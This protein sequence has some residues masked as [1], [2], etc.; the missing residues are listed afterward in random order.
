MREREARDTDL[1]RLLE[2][3]RARYNRREYVHPDPIEFLYEYDDPRDREVAGLVAAT[4]AC[5]RVM[6]ILA[7]VR[8]ALGR[9]G[10]RPARMVTTAGSQDLRD[11][12][13][14]FRHRFIPGEKLAALLLAAGR[15]LSEHGSLERAFLS[16]LDGASRRDGTV[17]PALEG[18]VGELV[19]LG[20][21]PGGMLPRP[22][23]GSACKRPLLWLRWMVRRDDVDPGGWRDVPASTLVVPMDT[24]MHRLSRLLGLTRRRQADLRAALEATAAFRRFAPEDPVKYDFALTR[25]GI[26]P[27]ADRE[28]FRAELSE[29]GVPA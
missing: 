19:R 27:D 2:G 6:Q 26:S 28:A 20:A 10:A 16:H 7:S 5:G 18:F 25:L 29:L 15:A 3:V 23:A 4:L 12:M 13:A 17:L 22:S 14:G 11:T 1:R 8:E 24:H 9:L 21:P